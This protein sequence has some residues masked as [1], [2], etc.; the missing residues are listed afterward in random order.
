VPQAPFATTTDGYKSGGSGGD[1]RKSRGA[2]EFELIAANIHKHTMYVQ[3]C[4]LRVEYSNRLRQA[5]PQLTEIKGR[6]NRTL[7]SEGCGTRRKGTLRQGLDKENAGTSV[8]TA[9]S[10]R[11]EHTLWN[12]VICKSPSGPF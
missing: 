8:R 9:E 1:L 12:T 11:V 7:K 6:T 10:C 5:G 3:L 4:Q 2:E